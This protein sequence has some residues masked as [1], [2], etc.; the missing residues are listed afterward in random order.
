MSSVE[1][2]KCHDSGV[3]PETLWERMKATTDEVR[4]RAFSLFERR[5]RA[6]GQD[7]DDWLKAEREVLWS[8]ASELVDDGKEFRAR[9]ALPGFDAKD[10]EVSAL[11]DA[12]VIQA[13]A[14]HTHEGQSGD[15]CFCEFS[16]KKLFRR[17][18][19][20]ASVDVD[21][22]SASLDKGVLQVTAPKT[23][24]RQLTAAA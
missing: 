9:V 14:T 8:P 21:K 6:I 13:E 15:V 22:V 2:K 20:P 19:L 7:L 10:I 12:L 16:G 18:A 3:L 17:L 4:Q 11:P 24:A 5:G 23:T 1:V